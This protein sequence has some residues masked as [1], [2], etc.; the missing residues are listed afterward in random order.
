M[1]KPCLY[2]IFSEKASLLLTVSNILHGF[3]WIEMNL[4]AVFLL[5]LPCL[6]QKLTMM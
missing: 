2:R 1:Y 4:N 5:V 3:M 6:P